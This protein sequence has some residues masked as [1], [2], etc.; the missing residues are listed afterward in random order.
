MSLRELFWPLLGSWTGTE[1]QAES[2]W[3]P[4]GAARAMVVFKLDVADRVVLQDYRQVRA[5]G[6]E[7]TA[8]GV[9]LLTDADRSTVGWWLFDS[10]GEPPVPATG[11]WSDGE[12]VLEKSTAR[13][14]ARHTFAVAAD[15]LTYRIET[16]LGDAP[17]FT[18][19][20]TGTYARISGH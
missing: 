7:F 17:D 6:A 5:D 10:Y 12:L 8:H 9:F 16:R 13:G 14:V 15:R 18:D 1:E 2:P 3:A 11:G 20:L 4:A 19:F